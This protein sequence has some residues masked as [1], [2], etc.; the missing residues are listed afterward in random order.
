MRFFWTAHCLPAEHYCTSVRKPACHI[1]NVD[2]MSIFF[3][4]SATLLQQVQ[5]K[6]Q[7]CA[8]K[9]TDEKLRIT[10]MLAIKLSSHKLPP[11]IIIKRKAMP[12]ENLP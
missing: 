1:G 11:Y 3:N 4:I 7:H 9:T 8:K 5:V 2:K 12:K 10:A 6:S